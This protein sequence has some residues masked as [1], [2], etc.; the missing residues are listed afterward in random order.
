MVISDLGR[1]LVSQDGSIPPGM[2]G[3]EIMNIP[4]GDLSRSFIRH[5]EV[6]YERSGPLTCSRMSRERFGSIAALLG[7]QN[8]VW[9]LRMLRSQPNG[10][11]RGFQQ[12][13]LQEQYSWVYLLGYGK[14]LAVTLSRRRKVLSRRMARYQADTML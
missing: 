2:S 13:L 8:D 7:Y 10:D 6:K 5:I 3:H 11:Y 4:P 12:L 9:H 1:L 14:K